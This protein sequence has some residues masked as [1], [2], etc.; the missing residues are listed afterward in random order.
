[1][2]CGIAVASSARLRAQST[3]EWPDTFLTRVETL[4]LVQTLNADILA[5]RSAT[6]TLEH[7]CRDHRLA[8]PA[9]IV[10]HAVKGAEKSPTR[11]QRQ[12]LEVTPA[13][14]IRYRH[15]QLAC[16]DHVLSEA[17]NWY[18]P[19]RLTPAMNRTLD[20]TET[21]FGQVVRPLQPYRE[22]FAVKMLWEPLSDG[23]ELAAAPAP[24][25]GVLRVPHAL[26]EHRAVLFTREHKAFS[27]VDE[28]YQREVLA[29]PPPPAE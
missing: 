22:T 21:P 6:T 16:G 13:E 29:F 3:P 7:W 1:M 19:S 8:S 5:S 17:D 24:K 18:V 26:F 14:P 10:A 25:S 11:E 15:V 27:E 4:A 2:V 20:S 23:W 9:T 28:V 12:R